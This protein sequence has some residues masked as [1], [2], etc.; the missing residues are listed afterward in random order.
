[1]VNVQEYRPCETCTVRENRDTDR[2]DERRVHADC[3]CACGYAHAPPAPLTLSSRQCTGE[4]RTGETSGLAH[5]RADRS[6]RNLKLNFELKNQNGRSESRRPPRS[7]SC[8]RL[9][10]SLQAVQCIAGFNLSQACTAVHVDA[11]HVRPTP[12]RRSEGATV[13]PRTARQSRPSSRAPHI[14]G[15]SYLQ[16]AVAYSSTQIATSTVSRQLSP[17]Y[18]HLC[19]HAQPAPISQLAR[20]EPVPSQRIAHASTGRIFWS[21]VQRQRTVPHERGPSDVGRGEMVDMG[22][23]LVTCDV[24][25]GTRR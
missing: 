25:D 7:R 18:F 3:G 17:P 5:R 12:A 9:D 2:S 15:S 4:M 19:P 24:T 1:M 10:I 16:G 11:S 22:G 23:W 14:P 6:Q 20:I 21:R 8:L 13:R